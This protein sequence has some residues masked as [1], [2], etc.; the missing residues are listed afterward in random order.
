V[1]ERII[2]DITP[3]SVGVW[4]LVFMAAIYVVREWRLTR[5]MTL[6]DRLARRDG[7]ARQVETLMVENRSLRA[8]MHVMN[9]N[10]EA[11][12]KLCH[13]EN[14]QLRDMIINLETEVEALK[15]LRAQ[16]QIAA[17]KRR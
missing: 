7:Y 12:R 10:H 13:Q 5:Q 3:S 4:I 8:E 2:A 16:D 15:R 6:E 14:D 17:V 9:E 11:Y 1:I